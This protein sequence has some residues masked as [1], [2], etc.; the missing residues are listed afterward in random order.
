M[1]PDSLQ[2]FRIEIIIISILQQIHE[3]F[4]SLHQPWIDLS[5]KGNEVENKGCFQDYGDRYNIIDCG[6]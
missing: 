5:L 3:H 4:L 6:L 1:I 2:K